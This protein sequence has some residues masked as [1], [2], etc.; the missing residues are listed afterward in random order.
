[1]KALRRSIARATGACRAA[2]ERC[3]QIA[4]E[5][6]DA[7]DHRE[8][9]HLDRESSSVQVWQAPLTLRLRPADRASRYRGHLDRERRAW[10]P[11]AA[12]DEAL[13]QP[14]SAADEVLCLAQRAGWDRCPPNTGH[15]GS[16]NVLQSPS[17]MAHCCHRQCR[18]QGPAIRKVNVGE[19]PV[20]AGRGRIEVDLPG[21][22]AFRDGY[23]ERH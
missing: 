4:V 10:P 8:Q 11:V 20:V 16:R 5:A 19:Q 23:E 13:D 14:I 6:G 22:D 12:G 9:S 21:F 17:S 18:N 2:K 3:Q 7:Y 1:M 15:H